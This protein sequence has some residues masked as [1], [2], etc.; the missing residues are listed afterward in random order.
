M[1]VAVVLL[2]ASVMM[3]WN[4][5][6]VFVTHER[7]P[8]AASV[9]VSPCLLFAD[10]C[11]MFA[12]DCIYR[13]RSRHSPAAVLFVLLLLLGGV[14]TNPGPRQPLSLQHATTLCLTVC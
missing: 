13:P 5:G 3:S 7:T 8:P 12:A 6:P 4:S 11:L 9:T 14:E 1:L 2:F 10:R